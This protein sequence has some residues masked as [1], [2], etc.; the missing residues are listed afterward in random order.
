MAAGTLIAIGT[1][2]GNADPATNAK[3]ERARA[4]I[5]GLAAKVKAGQ[6]ELVEVNAR[7][8]AAASREKELTELLTEG[9][10]HLAELRQRLADTKVQLDESRARLA[11]AREALSDRLIGIYKSGRPDAVDLI[12]DADGFDDLITRVEYLKTIQA[13]DEAL[14]AR[15]RA[16]EA[17]VEAQHTELVDLEQEA[18]SYTERLAEARDEIVGARERAAAEAA[19][20][21]EQSA[22]AGSRLGDLRSS[23]Q[24]WQS[25][26]ISNGQVG[27]W[28][29][30]YSIPTYI[31][32]C[33]S[34]GN[35]RA[36]NPSSGAGGAYQILPSTWRA[37]GGSGLPHQ[38]SKAEQDRIAALIWAGGAGRSQWVCA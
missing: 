34:G 9:R 27:S 32:M 18:E 8:D 21:R 29:G 33:E 22:A 24:D 15:V 2:S 14:A 36:L 30:G 37:Y 5:E 28:L 17:E 3:I 38:A 7:E 20:L 4:E 25:Q 31:V 35:Y 6:S 10:A 19:A 11:R 13:A 26:G 23:I 1:P 12:L 16:I